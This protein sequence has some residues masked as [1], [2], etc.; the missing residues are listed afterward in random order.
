MAVCISFGCCVFSL[1]KLA[2]RHVIRDL[3]PYICTS[4]ECDR[5]TESFPSLSDYKCHMIRA[6]ELP[7]SER[8]TAHAYRRRRE[9]STVCIFCGERTQFGIGDDD[10]GRH[11]ARHMEEIAFTVVTKAYEKWE[12]YSES[13]STSSSPYER[14]KPIVSKRK[15][16]ARRAGGKPGGK[17]KP[18]CREATNED[19]RRHRIPAGYS[20][21]NWDP[22]ER[23]IL[24]LGSVFD[25]NSLGKWIY[26]WTVFCHGA[27]TPICD[28]AG[29]LWLLLIKL[30]GRMAKI[31]R[32][33]SHSSTTYDEE[34]S[35][36]YL[37]SGERLWEQL[38][39]MVKD[40]EGPMLKANKK[41]ESTK[42][43][44]HRSGRE[45]VDTMFGR[46]RGLEATEAFMQGARLWCMRFDA[47]WEDT[48]KNE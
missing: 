48:C 47:N 28:V 41:T 15:V 18:L 16:T 36:E 46:D 39:K 45:F 17:A 27:Q 7:P 38:K 12:F 44:G 43:L 42:T 13:S 31:E 5:S 24:L 4:Q 25:A 20:L 40:C 22:V 1:T 33:L 9:E 30:A 8:S 6:H 14:S 10:R 29:E 21:K 35:N 26:D 11:V 32:R 2:R 19:A 37:S 34:T 23:P 3:R